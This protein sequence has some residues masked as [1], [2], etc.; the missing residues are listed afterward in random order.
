MGTER[1]AAYYDQVYAGKIPGK[2]QQYRQPYTASQYY[3][4]WQKVIDL[5]ETDYIIDFGCGVGHF[6]EVCAK[7]G[8]QQYRGIDFSIEAI[9]LAEN[10][11]L[12]GT[13]YFIFSDIL[14]Y[15]KF[16]KH[17]NCDFT[18][19]ETL[20]HIKQDRE[21]LELIPQKQ[22]IIATVPMFDCDTHVR[23]FTQAE[24]VQQRY[25]DLIDIKTLERYKSWYLFKCVK[26]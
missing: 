21:L 2:G 3:P 6:A 11:A 10:R 4:L 25:E 18:I 15:L 8:I 12:P 16:F 23:Y 14:T 1:D 20:E 19:L 17:R 24:Q 22:N 13:Y 5:V 9:N 26:R 7:R